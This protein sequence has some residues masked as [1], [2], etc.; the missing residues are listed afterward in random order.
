MNIFLADPDRQ[1]CRL[2]ADLLRAEGHEVTLIEQGRAAYDFL[3]SRTPDVLILEA[4]LPEISGVEL[5]YRLQRCYSAQRA[6]RVIV[7]TRNVDDTLRKAAKELEVDLVL[8]KPFSA[9]YLTDKIRRL[10][11]VGGN[12]TLNAENRHNLRQ[13]V[14][15]WARRSEGVLQAEL[16]GD[17]RWVLVAGGAPLDHED[18]P[19]FHKLLRGGHFCFEPCEVE[20]TGDY[21]TL[22]AVLWQRILPLVHGEHIAAHMDDLLQ[23]TALGEAA[24]AFPLLPPTRRLLGALD[25]SYSLGELL[26]AL[27][28]APNQV[29]R[30]LMAL[31]TLGMISF[32][33]TPSRH[34][35][36]SLAMADR[37]NHGHTPSVASA[38]PPRPE[39]PA[40]S[41]VQ[42]PARSASGPLP[43]AA[44]AS[45]TPEQSHSA[46]P[47]R[48]ATS[49]RD[50]CLSSVSD[51][52][53]VS[54]SLE[55]TP[56]QQLSRGDPPSREAS[57]TQRSR[58]RKRR[59]RRSPGS[60]G[61][62]LVEMVILKRLRREARLLK[63]SDPW[64]VLGVPRDARRAMVDK[65]G[66][67]ALEHYT[68]LARHRNNHIRRLATRLREQVEAALVEVRANTIE[69]DVEGPDDPAFREGILHL[70][71]GAWFEADHY[72]SVANN[73]HLANP[74]VL[75]YLG[76]C[77]LHNSRRPLKERVDQARDFLLLAIQFDPD[78]AE[79]HY[80]LAHLLHKEGH[81]DRAQ[82]HVRK[83]LQLEPDHQAAHKLARRL[84]VPG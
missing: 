54:R 72:L 16:D 59:A 66:G 65:I 42:S 17:T 69:M 49:S 19:V 81:E 76:W 26:Q 13:L 75:A 20:G 43:S 73:K 28:I 84:G 1:F 37:A 11:V 71:R 3:C 23:R 2:I 61:S 78:C 33:V 79:A 50:R 62:E 29:A 55:A 12:N 46:S 41:T 35:V 47:D 18:L 14:E 34:E 38:H 8:Q 9:R 74:V 80:F 21:E 6:P 30:D 58:K 70:Q 64:M 60:P 45:K 56:S 4:H 53:S 67:R 40:A 36:R 22:G 51:I 39:Q 44:P 25:L 77:R 15:I 57:S 52:S 7:A 32:A 31:R 63:E 5:L 48:S 82:F 27:N 68:R 24:L 83:A 10:G